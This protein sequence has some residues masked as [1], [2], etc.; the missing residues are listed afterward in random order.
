MQQRLPGIF[1]LLILLFGL[2]SMVLTQTKFTATITPAVISKE[3]TAELKLIVK[4]AGKVKWINLPVLNN[5]SIIS[6]P[7]EQRDKDP[8]KDTSVSLTYL[9]KPKV[10]GK[11]TIAAT[12]AMADGKII[13]SNAVNLAVQDEEKI[14]AANE[15]LAEKSFNDFILK[16]GE[17]K[18]QKISSNIFVMA[19]ASKTSCYIG[20]PVLV[21]YKLY[22]RLKS[23]S[24]FVKSP[25]LNGFSVIDLATAGTDK[26]VAEKFNGRDYY[27]CTLRKAQ[28]YPLQQGAITIEP[29]LV[30]NDICFIKEDYLKRNNLPDYLFRD[31]EVQAIPAEAMLKEKIMLESKPMLINVKPLPL[32]NKPVSF[33]GMVGNFTITAVLQHDSIGTGDAGR[34]RIIIQGEGNLPLVNLPDLVWPAGIEVPEPGITEVLNRFTVPVSGTKIFEY[35]FTVAKEGSYS[36]PAVSYSFF[37][38][39]AARYKT[40][41]TKPVLFIVR[42]GS[43][44]KPVLPPAENTTARESFSETLFTKRWLIIVPLAVLIF[45]GLFFWLRADEKKQLGAARLKETE[46]K[47]NDIGEVPANAVKNPLAHSEEMLLENNAGAFYAALNKELHIFLAATLQLTP[48]TIN[49]RSIAEGL[50]KSGVPVGTRITIQNL[51]DEISLQLYTPVSDE[52]K[53]QDYYEKAVAAIYAFDNKSA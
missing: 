16:E 35:T 14:N 53:L 5:F 20:E 1:L 33:N 27:V 41:S 24:N 46:Q 11:I 42:Q 2:H 19:T 18:A 8:L 51:L 47:N 23:E 3:E 6:G 12:T 48:E 17:N 37:D 50:D 30:E 13:K 28:L 36:I 38:V 43:G 49:K 7:N 21:T 15:P 29:A 34:L 40:I 22:T 52:S 31:M 9:L 26:Y 44:N 39:A 32:A 10:K 4:H 25:S 45:A